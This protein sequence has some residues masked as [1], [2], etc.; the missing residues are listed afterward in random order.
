MLGELY[1]S[2]I[3]Q[4]NSVRQK[5]II[6]QIYRSTRYGTYRRRKSVFCGSALKIFQMNELYLF[7]I[8]T[9]PS[10]SLRLALY[11]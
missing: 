4:T 10:I 1:P 9:D 6:M 2:F 7:I 8:H 5:S 11:R 3:N